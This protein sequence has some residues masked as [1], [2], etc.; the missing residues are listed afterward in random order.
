M[1]RILSGE[2]PVCVWCEVGGVDHRPGDLLRDRPIA[3]RQ[4]VHAVDRHDVV[5]PD[6]AQRPECFLAERRIIEATRGVEQGQRDV[7]IGVACRVR[8]GHLAGAPERCERCIPAHPEIARCPAPHRVERRLVAHPDGAQQRIA[9]TFRGGDT[10]TGGVRD[11]P[12]RLDEH[13]L[14]PGPGCIEHRAEPVRRLRQRGARSHRRCGAAGGQHQAARQCGGGNPLSP[15]EAG[16]G[17][18]ARS[19]HMPKPRV[20][21]WSICLIGEQD[22]QPQVFNLLV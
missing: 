9:L 20:R 4:H 18:G 13:L 5:L 22:A 14:V 15:S 19:R 11:A 7:R 3:G 8:I 10:A 16:L 2:S 12:I 6:R 21:T 17:P 1:R